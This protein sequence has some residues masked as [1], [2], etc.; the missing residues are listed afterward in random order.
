MAIALGTPA[1]KMLDGKIQ[2]VMKIPLTFTG[3]YAT[4]GVA[5]D[6]GGVYN[7]SKQPY[8]VHVEG[9][10][11]YEYKYDYTAKKLLTFTAGAELAAAAYP[12]GVTA[13]VVFAYVF[14]PKF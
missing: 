1:A 12:A 6:F 3:N 5:L 14:L 9:M 7:T 11:V 2:R 13:D 10:G 4:G 8:W